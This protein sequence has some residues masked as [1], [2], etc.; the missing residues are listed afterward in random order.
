[1][2]R[3]PTH[4][5]GPAARQPGASRPEAVDQVG[6][7]VERDHASPDALS[8]EPQR[9]VH[10]EAALLA[11]T[12]TLLLVDD[13]D[14]VVQLRPGERHGLTHV[15][16]VC[17]EARGA[18]DAGVRGDHVRSA[19]RFEAEREG[20]RAEPRG[21]RD[22]PD[23]GVAR[24]GGTLDLLEHGL[25]REPSLC[26]CGES[27]QEV[28]DARVGERAQAGAVEDQASHAAESPSSPTKLSRGAGSGRGSSSISTVS[29]RSSRARARVILPARRARITALLKRGER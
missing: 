12:P 2:A 16:R 5:V 4:E 6:S 27:F 24:F 8:H 28:E 3:G 29:H 15:L 26:M 11:D 23:V 20:R 14:R 13:R 25:G 18:Q 19:Q 21:G 7:F 9:A 1:M 17:P 10:L 22:S